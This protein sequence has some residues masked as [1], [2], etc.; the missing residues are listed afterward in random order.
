V[1]GLR[2]PSN[3][4]KEKE[5]E[6]DSPARSVHIKKN[7]K[8]K[9]KGKNKGKDKV[10]IPSSITPMDRWNEPANSNTIKR[11][12]KSKSTSRVCNTR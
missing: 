12:D 4:R 8:G 9:D 10:D 2:N 1:Y 7:D 6:L 3:K 5:N 11:K